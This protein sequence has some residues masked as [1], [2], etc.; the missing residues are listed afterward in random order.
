MTKIVLPDNL[1]LNGAKP[2]QI[3]MELKR[4][5]RD[6]APMFFHQK[7]GDGDYKGKPFEVIQGVDGATFHYHV[8]M[9]DKSVVAF[10][11]YDVIEQ[12]VTGDIA[13]P[14]AITVDILTMTMSGDRK[15]YYVRITHGNITYDVSKY[16][17]DYYNRALYERDMLRYALCGG[18][19]PDLMDDKYADTVE[20]TPDDGRPCCTDI[21]LVHV[22]AHVDDHYDLEERIDH[23]LH[24]AWD[25]ALEGLPALPTT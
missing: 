25:D 10:N 3:V 5:A 2:N 20:P 9:D 23:W 12:I 4:Y 15:D 17:G 11:A 7:V 21:F 8:R 14:D 19:K 6:K 13:I 16:G 1:N 18:K 22:K 24:G